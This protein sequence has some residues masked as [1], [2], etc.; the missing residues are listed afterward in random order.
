MAE[1][2]TPTV[3]RRR[4][5]VALREAR[6]AAALTQQQVADEMEWSLSKVI[7]IE[8]GEVS[9]APND[10]R[11]LLGFLGVKDKTVVSALLVDARIARTRQRQ[12]WWQSP[13]FRDVLGDH[14]RKLVEY[15]SEAGRIRYFSIYFIPGPLQIPEYAE[16]L[17]RLYGD[18]LPAEHARLKLDARQRR[19][20]ALLSRAGVVEVFVLLDESVLMRPIG[21]M[22]VHIGQL[23][24]LYDLATAGKIRL[25]M[26]PY[27][28]TA[29]VTNNATF[30]LLSLGENDSE[31]LLLYHESG[32]T[33]EAIETT[34][35]TERHRN[36]YD[37]V[38]REALN[39]TDT[40]DFVR[41]KIEQLDAQADIGSG[42]D[43]P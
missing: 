1:A 9:I 6:E 33:D 5:R 36:R 21:G 26:V 8:N 24:E 34:S 10:L 7:R 31:G 23:R 14:L 3:A 2:A 39:E 25:R 37:K 13:P 29:P 20:K 15:E 35:V 43:L 42:A 30:D 32:L 27:A 16:A 18:E 41:K 4:V 28:L 19:R 22:Q 11:P 17:M 12:A 40:I 38:W